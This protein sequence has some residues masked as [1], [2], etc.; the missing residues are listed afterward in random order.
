MDQN[1]FIPLIYDNI[2]DTYIK[3]YEIDKI[4]LEFFPFAQ[5]VFKK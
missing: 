2:I 4:N 5:K 1:L 3:I